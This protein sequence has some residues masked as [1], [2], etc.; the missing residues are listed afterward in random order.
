MT[1]IQDNLF[2]HPPFFVEGTLS[3]SGKTIQLVDEDGHVHAFQV[4]EALVLIEC[5]EAQERY[6]DLVINT[7]AF[8]AIPVDFF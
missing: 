4:V 5:R 2:Q 3:D 6:G 7:E 8:E 1:E